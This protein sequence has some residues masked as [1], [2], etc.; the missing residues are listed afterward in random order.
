MKNFTNKKNYLT[1]EII[2]MVQTFMIL[3]I[4]QYLAKLKMKQVNHQKPV[5]SRRQS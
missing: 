1:S 3:Q 4:T 5:N 2:K